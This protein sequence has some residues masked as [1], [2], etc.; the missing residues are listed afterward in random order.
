MIMQHRI[1]YYR[2]V[3]VNLASNEAQ[4]KDPSCSPYWSKDLS[5]LPP[6]TILVAEYD[7]GR[8]QSEAYAQKLVEAVNRVTKII[9]PG[10]THATILY[11]K[12]LSDGQDPAYVVA[13]QIRKIIKP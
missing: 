2:L 8:S 4:R 1:N 6:T 11:R 10:Q 5:G 13:E 9:F 12:A 7:G 3:K